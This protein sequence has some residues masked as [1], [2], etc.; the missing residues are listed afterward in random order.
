[1]LKAQRALEISPVAQL[2]SPPGRASRMLAVSYRKRTKSL[3]M[4]KGEN[5]LSILPSL[6]GLATE[7][8]NDL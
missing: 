3:L 2:N 7:F 1:M 5:S 6:L 4:R 8:P